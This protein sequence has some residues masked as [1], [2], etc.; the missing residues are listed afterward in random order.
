[1]NQLDTREHKL[2]LA[3]VLGMLISDGMLEQSQV[4]ALIAARRGQRH[5][6]H[7]LTLIA[8]QNWRSATPPNKLLH[9]EALTEWLAQRTG[10]GYFHIDP[11]KIDFT[12]VTDIMSSDYAARFGILP[13]QVNAS[14][15]VI[16]TSEPFLR[17]W[18]NVIKPILRKDIRRVVASPADIS[19]YLVEFYNLARSVKSAEKNNRGGTSGQA[20]FEQLV[21]IGK[22]NRQF[23][24]NDQ[25]IVHIVDWLWQ[26]AFEQRA[27]DIHIEPRRDL[28][29][30]RFRIDGVLHQVYQVPM[31]VMTAMTSRIKVMGRMDLVEKRRPQDGRIKTRTADGQEIE[32]RLSTLPTAFG[33]KLVM[34]IFDPE[35][36]VRD[37]AE[38]GFS[39]EDLARWRK[40]TEQP[41]GIILVTGP[42]GSGKTTTLYST[43]KHLATPEVNVCTIEDPIEM[44]EPAFNQMQVQHGLDLGFADGVRALMRQDPD[45]IMIGEIRDLE[46]AEM[47]IQAALTGHLVLST[48]HTNDAP[49]A[50]TRLLDLGVAPFMINATL[51]G[52]MG[53]RLV[54]TLCPHCKKPMPLE[55]S[56]TNQWNELVAP[57][58][59]NP[60]AQIHQPE[61][62]LECRMTGYKG[63]VGI[64]EILLMSPALRKLVT[65]TTD[66]APLREQ[67][68]K[69]GMKPLRI[70]GALKVANGLT[71]LEEVVRVA[72]P[73]SQP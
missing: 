4:D 18:E 10:L 44:V 51:L 69:E 3:E 30:V 35:V 26:Y 13:V 57:W 72:P 67:A 60:P 58:K 2:T 70:S 47:A 37:F 22:S 6:S 40:M 41:N 54:R 39:E 28:G 45:I 7:P 11:L 33:E 71:T 15:V 29:I 21:E 42:T 31:S 53:Q 14:E 19:R 43:L 56:E 49:S 63:R 32:L 27:S 46:T 73:A 16:A 17:E 55:E 38:L 68:S 52:V 8:D 66:I 5:D 1:M 50:I 36:L 62:C 12:T 64:Y 24:A 20:S 25:N 48:L 65:P 59:A 23:D 34:R 9:V 61:G